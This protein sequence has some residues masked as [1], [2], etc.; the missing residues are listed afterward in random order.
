MYHG[1]TTHDL[2]DPLYMIEY[3]Y[4]DSSM[5]RKIFNSKSGLLKGRNAARDQ[6]RTGVIQDFR[7][8]MAKNP[9][10]VHVDDM[11]VLH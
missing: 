7:I 1:S 5:S 6:K 4:E 11:R 10:W 2:G 8:L 3:Q 9:E